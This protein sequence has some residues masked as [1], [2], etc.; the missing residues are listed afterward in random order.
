MREECLP[1]I[2]HNTDKLAQN[3]N[4]GEFLIKVSIGKSFQISVAL[5]TFEGHN[6]QVYCKKMSSSKRHIILFVFFY[7]KSVSFEA[8]DI[9]TFQYRSGGEGGVGFVIIL[10]FK[11]G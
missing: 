7:L 1:H 4:I 2:N 6:N 5:F 3:D 9:Q 11:F 10:K 8:K